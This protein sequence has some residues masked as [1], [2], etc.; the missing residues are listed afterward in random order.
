MDNLLDRIKKDYP[1]LSFKNGKKF[2]FRPP[3]TIIIGPSEPKMELLLLHELGHAL[4]HHEDYKTH[5]DR[6]KMES[7][8]WEK[9]KELSLKYD[10]EFDDDLMQTE[11]DTYRDWLYKKSRC[12]ICGLTR[13]QTPDF[14]YH[15]PR[16]ELLL[17]K[18]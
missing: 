3:K 15:C 10:V 18:K 6:L 1:E 7:D 2:T 5:V 14:K 11:L 13:F 4:L 17:N 9:A 12:P 8:A 16:C